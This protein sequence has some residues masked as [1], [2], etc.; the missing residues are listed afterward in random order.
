MKKYAVLLYSL[1]ISTTTLAQQSSGTIQYEEVITMGNEDDLKDAPP[2]LAKL[3]PRETKLRKLL[4]YTGKASM[5]EQDKANSESPNKNMN[6]DGMQIQIHF[7]IPENRVY[8][9]ME[10][11]KVVMLQEFMSRKFLINSDFAARNWKTTGQQK[12][13]LDYPCMEAVSTAGK[14]TVTAWFTSSIPVSGGPEGLAGLPGMILE[15]QLSNHHTIRAVKVD[16]GKV[17]AAVIKEPKGGKKVTK[18]EFDAIVKAKTEEM[19]KEMGGKG[20]NMI[21]RM[22]TR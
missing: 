15:A 7:E 3:I 4:S 2:E 6:T 11:K 8:T 18:E 13:I 16:E 1:A 22:E 12:K 17:D 19:E 9:D 14:D 10:Q 5:Y 21:F 20:G